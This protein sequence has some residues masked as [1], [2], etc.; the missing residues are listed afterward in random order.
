MG[1]NKGK[2]KLLRLRKIDKKM[3]KVINVYSKAFL[4]ISHL[5]HLEF[6]SHENIP[7]RY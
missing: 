7:C 1:D 2:K 5:Y 3:K 4:K 6:G